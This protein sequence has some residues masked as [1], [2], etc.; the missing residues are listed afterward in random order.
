MPW[1]MQSLKEMCCWPPLLLVL[2][3]HDKRVHATLVPWFEQASLSSRARL[4]DTN[5]M[6]ETHQSEGILSFLSLL[7]Q[8]RWTREI[9]YARTSKIG[10]FSLLSHAQT[11][12]PRLPEDF[13]ESKQRAAKLHLTFKTLMISVAFWRE[14]G[15][16]AEG[17]ENQSG[18]RDEGAALDLKQ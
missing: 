18:E 10:S 6:P 11:D 8:L 14:N 1:R 12:T 4:W 17:R 5:C 9:K 15:N 13:V 3:L 16:R 2:V 7:P